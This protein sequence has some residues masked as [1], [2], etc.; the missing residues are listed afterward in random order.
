MQAAMSVPDPAATPAERLDSWK[1]IAAYLKKGIRTVQ[2]WE[3]SEGLPVHRLDVDRPGSVFAYKSELDSWWQVRSRV[4]AGEAEATEPVAIRRMAVPPGF[5]LGVRWLAAGV[6]LGLAM[7]GLWWKLRPREIAPS[8]L[9][10]KPLTSDPGSEAQPTFSPDGRQVAYIG[11]PPDRSHINIY[12]AILGSDSR[13]KITHS[14][15]PDIHPAWSPDGRNI[16]FLRVEQARRKF[17]VMLISPLGGQETMVTEL[18]A[19][20][21][22]SWSSD[23]QW[24]ISTDG[25]L[26]NP[27]AIAISV[28]TGATHPVSAT[29][30]SGDSGAVLSPDMKRLYINR[31][32][33]NSARIFEQEL[34]PGLMPRGEARAI[35]PEG[36][37]AAEPVVRP[38]GKA[39]LYLGPVPQEAGAIWSLP[40]DE[41]GAQPHLLYSPQGQCSSMAISADGKRLVFDLARRSGVETWRKSLTDP[42]AA[43][44]RVLYTTHSEL[45]P[46]YSP[47][48]RYIAFHSTRTGDS[49]IWIADADGSHT[50]RLTFTN[51][52]ITATPR[53]S[54]DGAWI[55]FESN[56]G[57]QTAVYTIR[58]AG[59]PARR[60]TELSSMNALP[61]W[62]RDGRWLYFTSNRSG[63]N[64]IWKMP[65]NGGPPTQMTQGGGW[66]A[67]ESPDGRFLYYTQRRM[68][69]PLWRLPVAGGEPQQ[70]VPLV[71]S[72]FFAVS[73]SGVY[74]PSNVH[75]ISFWEA[76][77]GRT[78]PVINTPLPMD[79][80]LAL[81]PD[82]K[83]LLFTQAEEQGSDLYWIDGL[84]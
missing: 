32:T 16:A 11:R 52:P 4:L 25:A 26:Q 54:P 6:L 50:R 2:R 64:E 5:F 13:L 69:G 63:R 7:A 24:L 62:S 42:K 61:S 71:T 77:T 67:E 34:G 74:F 70:I 9:R 3:R 53:W 36:V 65:S 29:T 55:A 37:L 31:K 75:E 81:S 20:R 44:E 41:S 43:P 58:S 46:H 22:L 48:G 12:V 27:V 80:G 83:S 38:D 47:D 82:G 78:T 56:L 15:D 84:R 1:E 33:V 59:G 8:A 57:G 18:T 40:L 51:A 17:A 39:L 45:N 28:A 21:C 79:I 49:D 60:L 66:V 30:E 73:E 23:G 68:N 14:S 35:T 72:L 10:A 19:A 76:A